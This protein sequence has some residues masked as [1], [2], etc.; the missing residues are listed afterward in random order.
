MKD[1]SAILDTGFTGDIQIDPVIASELGLRPDDIME[2]TIAGENRISFPIATAIAVM[3]L[4]GQK[5]DV[6][7]GAGL[8][9]VGIGFL[10][11]FGYTA[12]VDCKHKKVLLRKA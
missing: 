3:E 6:L 4:S 1:I 9:L 8:P 12:I 2:V 10:T 5:M 7:I 11:K